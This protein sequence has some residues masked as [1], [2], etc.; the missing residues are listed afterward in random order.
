MNYGELIQSFCRTN[1][2]DDMPSSFS[3]TDEDSLKRKQIINNALA[4][5]FCEQ[6]NFRKDIITFQTV[7]EQSIYDMPIGI[8]DKQGIRVD[9][10]RNPLKLITNPYEMETLNGNPWGYYVQ[11]SKLVLY[12]IPIDAR[13]VTVHYLILNSALSADGTPQI[14]LNLEADVPNIPLTFHDL[15]VKKAEL[16]YMRDKP[17]KNNAQAKA[18]VQKRISQLIDLD[19]G[20]L[21]AH[22]II[23]M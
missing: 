19:R 10:I 1:T 18:D 3:A 13:T 21:E 11:G 8:I 6:W 7:A 23:V 22:P 16:F 5:I 2:V 17:N 4:E 14:G 12:P 15:I 9:G 20:T